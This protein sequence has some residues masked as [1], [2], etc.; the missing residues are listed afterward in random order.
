MGGTNVVA[1][2]RSPPPAGSKKGRLSPGD[3]DHRKPKS[4]R[5][6]IPESVPRSK[7]MIR[8]RFACPT[9]GRSEQKGA[10]MS[11]TEQPNVATNEAQERP[12]RPRRIRLPVGEIVSLEDCLRLTA[13][14]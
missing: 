14:L 1:D 2:P 6:T 7:P 5:S 13:W 12:T 11:T 9:G 3:G 4:T 10:R 8:A